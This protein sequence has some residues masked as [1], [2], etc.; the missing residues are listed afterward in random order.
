MRF[1]VPPGGVGLAAAEEEAAPAEISAVHEAAAA[2][3]ATTSSESAVG[4]LAVM[5]E[6]QKEGLGIEH[7]SVSPT[8]LDQV[9]LTIVGKHNVQEEGYKDVS[10]K[11]RW[12]CGF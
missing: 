10:Q 6:E 4:R 2:A 11:S 3:A 8:T 9:F 1:S 5:L 7:Y 12:N